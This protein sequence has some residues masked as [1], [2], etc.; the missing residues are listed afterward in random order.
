MTQVK[1]ILDATQEEL[2]RYSGRQL[3]ES[4]RA[5]EGRT[6]VAETVVTVPPLVDGCSNPEVAAAFGADLLL[7]NLYDVKRPMVTGFPS[8]TPVHDLPEPLKGWEN[9]LGW[10]VTAEQVKRVTG[11]PVGINLEPA[12]RHTVSPGRL[13]TA[14]NAVKAREQ[15]VDFLT[16]TGNPETGVTMEAIIDVLRTIRAAVG[17]DLILMAGKMH[18]AGTGTDHWLSEEQ[19]ARVAEAGCDVLLLPHAGTVPGVNH[20]QLIRWI[21]AAHEAGMLVMLT[22][23]TSQEGATP[24]LL[25]TLAVTGKECGADLYHIGDAG[26]SGMAP[27]ENIMAYAIALKGKRHTYRRMAKRR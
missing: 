16:L 22:V 27:P 2:T 20:R 14:D 6:V 4:I 17:E 19:I 23:G 10:G 1:R 26:F 9:H 11:R 13:A 24:S 7:L 21:D 12:T 15:G 18:G 8:R 5:A 3:L 25:E